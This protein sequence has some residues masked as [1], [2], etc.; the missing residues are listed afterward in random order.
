MEDLSPTARRLIDAALAEDE[1]DEQGASE[2]WS[3][4]LTG[5]DS[6]PGR[7][8]TEVIGS[9]QIE[10]ARPAVRRRPAQPGERIGRYFVLDVLGK[11]AMGVVYRAYD[12]EL[13]RAVALKV[14]NPRYAARRD[15]DEARARLVSEARALARLSHPNVTAIYDVGTHEDHVYLAME[16]VEGQDLARWLRQEQRSWREVVQVFRSAAL[17]VA[18]AHDNGLVHRDIKPA[19]ILLG[20]DGRVR[21]TDFGIAR[22]DAP[23]PETPTDSDSDLGPTDEG[24]TQAGF[25][26]GTPAYMAPEQHQ[27]EPVGPA[28]DQYALC[29][30]LYEAL[31]GRRPFRGS[32]R[33]MA[34]AKLEARIPAGG[35]S[36]VPR[37][38]AAVVQ[39]GL[40][41]AP[42]DRHA[43]V[44]GLYEALG[45]DPARRR[46]R[47]WAVA[48]GAGVVALGGV[49]WAQVWS[50][51][52]VCEDL[53]GR[54]ATVW[55]P[56]RREQVQQAFVASGRDYAPDTFGRVAESLDLRAAAWVEMRTDACQ[57]T[58]VR[59]EQSE[60]MLDLRIACLDRRLDGVDALVE[61][62]GQADA[63]VVDRALDAVGRLRSLERCADTAALQAE[64]PPPEDDAAQQQVE[65]IR[66]GLAAAR[67]DRH[68][69]RFDDGLRAAE[70]ARTRSDA[71]GY[72]PVQ[73]EAM[74]VQAH[75][76]DELG[77]TPE[78]LTLAKRALWA[79]QEVGHDQTAA[80]SAV[81]LVWLLSE[82]RGEPLAGLDWAR[83]A[84]AT[85][86]RAGGDDDLRGQLWLNE[87][88]ARVGAGQFD[89]GAA[90][91][92]RALTH[93][94]E[95][96]GED[97]PAVS[98]VV[99]NSA[100]LLLQLGQ[101][102]PA[103]AK[104]RDA[105]QRLE[106]VYGAGHPRCA[107]ARDAMG[108]CL[109]A[110][111]RLPEAEAEHQ[112]AIT[113]LSEALGPDHPDVA[114]SLMNLAHVYD[115]MQR[116]DDAQRLYEQALKQL[117]PYPEH[118]QLPVALNN[119]GLLHADH[120]N[121][122][123]GLPLVR[124]AFDLLEARLGPRHPDLIHPLSGL[125]R[126]HTSLGQTE[127]ALELIDRQHAL[128]VA[129][130]GPDHRLAAVALA[131][132]GNTL[133]E[134]DRL[135]E[136]LERYSACLA[137]FER[138]PD[139]TPTDLTISLNDVN[140]ALMDLGRVDEA[141]PGLER[142][143]TASQDER[144]TPSARIDA[145][146]NMASAL[147]QRGEDFERARTLG[148][149]TLSLLGELGPA[150][151][152]ARPQVE[153]WLASLPDP[154]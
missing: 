138:N 123:E 8:Q 70:A 87:G 122:A 52:A 53:G 119:L 69:G 63:A 102:E 131:N 35:S 49:G 81:L 16:L 51:Q 126:L 62:L 77:R 18:A 68:A 90:S 140:S 143:L 137:A 54:M 93:Y 139:T 117:G 85:L 31:H 40:Q 132:M 78:A 154:G 43:S 33:E 29:V 96:F 109:R 76:L 61:V 24:I 55:S 37:W 72:A 82:R 48:A 146:F 11:G 134:A 30:A 135:P 22:V 19:N 95:H 46:R 88:A 21:V 150:G 127:K 84:E 141:L 121:P 120:G 25:V 10:V 145:T 142:A 71:V 130:H 151:E 9:G 28:A 97:H 7:P 91:Y 115:Q 41:V 75:L 111:G 42:A 74:V 107:V 44:R 94:R 99:F 67:A 133:R 1:P 136:A 86:H 32:S 110:L 79:A 64:V 144:V 13:E 100:N 45:N 113:V 128:A 103:L 12:P 80:E 5:I 149:R 83:Y 56:Q 27:G 73:A 47:W 106:R 129:A 89:E 26:V 17:G 66:G 114:L 3:L 98:R 152:S 101:F 105:L 104:Y 23:G 38:V 124:R 57:A 118:P 58:R 36:Q 112:Q 15:V 14:V 65:S 116:L 60:A 108:N 125:A 2:S 6:A 34:Y 147:A 153:A 50:G 4:V 148:Q 59:R 92:E 39:H 20:E